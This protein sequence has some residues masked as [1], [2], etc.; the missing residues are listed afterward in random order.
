MMVGVQYTTEQRTFMVEK[1]IETKRIDTVKTA[2]QLFQ[3]EIRLYNSACTI[4]YNV[5]KFQNNSTSH[6]LNAYI[7]AGEPLKI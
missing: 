4:L 3:T 2:F 6:N 1:Y 5:K 7:P